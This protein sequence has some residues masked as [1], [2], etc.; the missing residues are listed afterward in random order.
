M[1]K[2]I[3][4]IIAIIL[5]N[6]FFFF[7]L[8][9]ETDRR[10]KNLHSHMLN[11]QQEISTSSKRLFIDTWRLIKTKYY[12]P[13]LN[14]QDWYRWKNHYL[15][16]IKTNEDV[17]VAINSMLASL[18]DPYSKFMN[19][20]EFE[21]QNINIDAKISGIGVTITSISGKI[22][23]VNV[24]ENSPAQKAGLKP[25]DT[26]V[27][28]DGKEINGMSLSDVSHIL[29]GEKGS[30][31]KV[32]I[33]RD[34]KKFDKTIIRDEVKLKSVEFKMLDDDIAYIQILTF[35]SNDVVSE[36][37]DAMAKTSSSKGI[38][39]DL[40]GNTGGLLPAAVSIANVFIEKGT[41]VSIVDRNGLQ[42]TIDAKFSPVKIKK[43]LVVLTDGATASAS[44]ILSG[45]LKDYQLATLVGKKTFGEAMIQKIYPLANH[46]G[47]NLT[48]GKYLTPNGTDINKLGIEPNYEVEFTK[49]DFEE[50]KDPQL[51]KAIYILKNRFEQDRY[52]Q[53]LT[54]EEESKEEESVNK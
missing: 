1:K 8:I 34:K 18:N 24:I 40:R 5:V 29:R 44:E 49:K 16:H 19:K 20:D 26:I 41:I 15:P 54:K 45:A 35:I 21:Q 42:S 28:V 7:F 50:N 53:E 43:P 48:I 6:I 10:I 27:A 13:T 37:F 4:Y 32:T 3:L 17:Y 12:D 46:M 14:H 39:L 11:K 23:I 31:V 47:M 52:E 33:L 51:D 36:T 25:D 30:S 22:K 2:K 38:I 9:F